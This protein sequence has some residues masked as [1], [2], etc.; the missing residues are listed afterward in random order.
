MLIKLHVES[1]GG[2]QEFRVCQS[3]SVI[4]GDGAIRG[5]E[6]KCGDWADP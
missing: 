3:Y 5:H 2:G 1:L 6:D 4:P